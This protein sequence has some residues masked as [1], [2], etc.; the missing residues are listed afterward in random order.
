MNTQLK[1]ATNLTLN[2]QLVSEA[3]EFKVNLSRAAEEGIRTA[4][5][6]ARAEIWRK[7]NTSALES[8]NDYVKQNGLPLL[9][10]RQF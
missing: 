6:K 8:S 4:L 7:D 3:R 1:K 9:G 5:Q 2:S 10:L